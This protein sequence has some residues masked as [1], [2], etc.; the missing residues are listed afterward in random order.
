MGTRSN[1]ARLNNDGSYDVIYCHWDGYPSNNGKL[2]LGHYQTPGKIAELLALGSL[3]S[4]GAEI[5]TKHDFETPQT[6]E[7]TAYG[8][9][10]GQKDN[11]A[12]HY[13][14]HQA[15]CDGLKDAW[16]E[17]LYVYSIPEGRW[18]YSPLS[19]INLKPLT[20]EAWQK[21]EEEGA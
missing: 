11:E 4:L 6:G 13:K 10:R 5:G 8:R 3:S 16:T 18:L 12:I 14:D 1:I 2:L 21:E 9:D 19:E 15:L 20:P 7:C 17:W